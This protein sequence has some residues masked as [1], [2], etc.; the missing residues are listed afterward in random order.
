MGLNPTTLIFEI[1][2]FLILLWL[3]SK[4]LYKPLRQAIAER[5]K[6]LAEEHE[7]SRATLAEVEE[8]KRQWEEKN[9]QLLALADKVRS[10]ALEDAVTEQGRILERAREEAAT[11]RSKALS[12]VHAERE[13]AEQW[14][15]S[16]A[17]ARSTDLAGHMVMA[18]APD[19]V[20][21]ALVNLLIR[22]LE[23]RG[24]ELLGGGE[25]SDEQDVEIY[26]VHAPSEEILNRLRAA[27]SKAMAAAPRWIMHE[28]PSVKAGVRLRV[29]DRIVDASLSGQLEAFHHLARE[30]EQ[31]D[32]HG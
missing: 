5:E 11:E 32:A 18:L 25:F 22:E 4:V 27:L 20:D 17:I 6:S 10:E 26:A 16:V 2:N 8:L 14:V 21:E 13:A 28:D 7:H 24:S 3:L 9:Q 23:H 29:G 15:R 12:M 30:L 1:I 19:A 31:E